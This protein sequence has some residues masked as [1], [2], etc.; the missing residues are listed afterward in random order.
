VPVEKVVKQKQPVEKK[1]GF[2]L[3]PVSMNRGQGFEFDH[4]LLNE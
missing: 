4:D 3:P 1:P 2:D